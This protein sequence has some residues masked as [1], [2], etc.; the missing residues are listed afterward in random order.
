MNCL[1]RNR[2]QKLE[3]GKVEEGDVIYKLPRQQVAFL[4][5]C[6]K[7]KGCGSLREDF[8]TKFKPKKLRI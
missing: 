8:Y 3:F 4:R 7:I 6:K 2:A 5:K 1:F